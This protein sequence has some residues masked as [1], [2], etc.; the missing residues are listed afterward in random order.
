LPIGPIAA[1]LPL[2]VFRVQDCSAGNFNF[3]RSSAIVAD[4]I[5]GP[6]GG[7]VDGAAVLSHVDL[8]GLEPR[9]RFF[10]AASACMLG[11]LSPY[12][13]LVAGHDFDRSIEGI[14]HD[15]RRPLHLKRLRHDLLGGVA[16]GVDES[17]GC[18][19]KS[20]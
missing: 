4:L 20:K 5:L 1:T 14:D 6:A 10:L 18:R 7:D 9:F 13:S 11:H 12:G 16:I 3:D 17:A 2:L 19:S 8:S 15:F